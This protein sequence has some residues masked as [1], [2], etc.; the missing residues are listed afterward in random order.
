MG[1]WAQL[2]ASTL[3]L[4]CR[5]LYAPFAAQAVAVEVPKTATIE[6]VKLAMQDSQGIPPDQQRYIY[7]GKRLEDG[8]K[9]TDYNI[10]NGD[11][12]YCVLRLPA[13]RAR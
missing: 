12:I 3:A 2:H 9:L 13:F 7:R 11:E 5:A 4:V 8:R 1:A 10:G 6:M